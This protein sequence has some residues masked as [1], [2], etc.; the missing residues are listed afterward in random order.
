MNPRKSS[1]MTAHPLG[2]AAA[3]RSLRG[4]SVLAIGTLRLLTGTLALLTFV[5]PAAVAQSVGDRV[6]VVPVS[7]GV[8]V[9]G[10]VTSRDST[11]IIIDVG[12]RDFRQRFRPLSWADI[13]SVE[14][15]VGTSNHALLGAAIGA[16]VGVAI[17]ASKG[18]ASFRVQGDEVAEPE[19]RSDGRAL[20]LLA[21]GALVGAG[22]GWAIKSDD[23]WEEIPIGDD[24]AW[25][26]VVDAGFAP[27]GHQLLLY[28]GAR[29]RFGGR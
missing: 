3:R 23:R 12:G 1:G 2:R 28:V 15:S 10:E 13:E 4:S 26:P 14:R 20:A 8:S 25:R 27:H 19:N 11:G 21:G 16:A 9:V 7:T 29:L 5:A 18:Y 17:A 22:V 6:R 24:F